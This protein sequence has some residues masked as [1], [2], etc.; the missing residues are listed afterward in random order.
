MEKEL[1]KA[2]FHTK[3]AIVII[4]LE[5]KAA[6]RAVSSA[7]TRFRVKIVDFQKIFKKVYYLRSSIMFNKT[8]TIIAGVLVL[9]LAAYMIAKEL[10]YQDRPVQQW[11]AQQDPQ[12]NPGP[13]VGRGGM[14]GAPGEGLAP[15]PRG[16]VQSLSAWFDAV[17]QAYNN[18]NQQR[19]TQ[20]I[21]RMDNVLAQRDQATR[22]RPMVQNF[23]RW[24]TEF[25]NAHQ[26]GE[27][28]R[29]GNLITRFEQAR[30]QV[31][32]G[33]QQRLGQPQPDR[34]LQPA[35]PQARIRGDQP[36]QP[37]PPAGQPRGG[38]GRGFRGG[39]GQPLAPQG[40][41]ARSWQQSQ[42]TQPQ[43]QGR[44]GVGRG[45][46]GGPGA[47]L[48]R[49]LRGGR[50]QI[51]LPPAQRGWGWRVDVRPLPPPRRFQQDRWSERQPMQ[52]QMRG[53]RGGGFGGMGPVV[54]GRPPETFTPRTPQRGLNPRRGFIP[55]E[56]VAPVQP[57]QFEW[58]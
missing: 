18:G 52:P 50:S 53:P 26:N 22:E 39:R 11:Q 12:W 14:R 46:R 51:I 2:V 37:L 32:G 47:G 41:A 43:I 9:G 6:V 42:P 56:N 27:W 8:F 54:R 28:Q 1:K 55:E 36:Q 58:N 16:P 57:Q 4:L 45:F 19:L 29:M 20:L 49:G 15:M 48:G 13:M 33:I 35:G 5:N 23:E 44:P 40:P 30:G 21:R 10:P 38:Y 17:K 34:P 25:K 3:A 7:L 31:R 24:F